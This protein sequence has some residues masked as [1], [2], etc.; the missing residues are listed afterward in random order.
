MDIE[1]DFSKPIEFQNVSFSYPDF[2]VVKELTFRIEPKKMTAIVGPSGA[3]KTTIFNLLA[4]IIDPDSGFITM[5]GVDT[6]TL[7]KKELRTLISVV[8]QESGIFDETI[9]ENIRYGNPGDVDDKGSPFVEEENYSKGATE[10]EI[11]YAAEK[12]RVLDFAKQLP[13]GLN[14]TCGPR[15][16][17]LSGGQRQR[18]AIARALLKPSPVLLL[19]EPTSALDANTEELIQQ[20]LSERVKQQTIIVIAHRLSTIKN[21]NQILVVREGRILEEGNHNDLMAKKGLY[22]NLYYS[23]ELRYDHEDS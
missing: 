6:R 11:H 14:S 10:E 7:P 18:I 12:A 22:S 2:P 23:Q 20:Y 8:A 16:S 1:L 13:K 15:G 17:K 19:D 4:G 21:A 9:R 5:G 3:G